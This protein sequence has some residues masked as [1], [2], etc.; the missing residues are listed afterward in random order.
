MYFNRHKRVI[1]MRRRQFLTN[2]IGTAVMAVGSGKFVFSNIPAFARSSSEYK[3]FLF[4]IYQQAVQLGMNASIMRHALNYSLPNKK[5]IELD[6][7]QPEFVMTWQQYYKKVI[8]A[9]KIEQGRNKFQELQTFLTALWQSYEVDPSILVGIWGIESFYGKFLGKFNVID[10]LATL[11]YEGR[12]AKFFKIEL[13]NALRI[14]N[15]RNINPENMMGSYAGAM[16]QPQF[17]PSAYLRYAVDFLGNGHPNIWTNE[18]D[19][20]ASIANYLK[21]NG[22]HGSEPWGQK[23]L[24]P[25]DFNGSYIGHHVSKTLGEWKSMGVKRSDGSDFSRL[26]IYGS[27]LKPDEKNNNGFMIYHNFNVIRRYNPSDY[28]A[29]AVGLLGDAMI[30]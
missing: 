23:I 24:L 5:V 15:H 17:M 14:L 16:G 27:I 9:E 10:A 20:L 19:V 7:K 4:N 6:H 28:Y 13:M 1:A 11:A 25:N 8:T 21:K 2:S 26:D 22:W 30:A 29:L 12:R 18:K 3:S